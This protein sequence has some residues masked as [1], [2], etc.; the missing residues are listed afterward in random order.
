MGRHAKGRP[1]SSPP[2]VPGAAWFTRSHWI[3]CWVIHCW[4]PPSA[5]VWSSIA[6]KL[7]HTRDRVGGDPRATATGDRSGSAGR[8]YWRAGFP[9]GVRGT[10]RRIGNRL[11]RSSGGVD[12]AG[13]I[14]G[15][16][17][18]WMPNDSVT[19][20]NAPQLLRIVTT[21]P[22]SP[23][24]DSLLGQQVPPTVLRLRRRPRRFRPGRVERGG[25]GMGCAGIRGQDL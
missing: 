18:I 19:R 17:R 22:Q 15:R 13:G 6:A 21:C 25:G 20:L 23:R 11:R 2:P 12:Q 16:L 14:N 3:R 9:P 5:G 24:G 10:G 7:E 8:I 4:A 1:W